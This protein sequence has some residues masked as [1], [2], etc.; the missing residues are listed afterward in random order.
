MARKTNAQLAAELEA[1]RAEIDALKLSLTSRER[2]LR[3]A[4]CEIDDLAHKV[5]LYQR[6]EL[7]SDITKITSNA[8][9]MAYARNLARQGTACY[10]R[11]A[12][13]YAARTHE[14]IAG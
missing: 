4:Q 12:K 10:A 3:E 8:E 11:G 5:A 6:G 1:R 13:V 2:E 9:A 7:R 14:L